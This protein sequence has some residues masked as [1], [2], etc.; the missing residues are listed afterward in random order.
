MTAGR[1]RRALVAAYFLAVSLVA[2]TLI[3][4][5]YLLDRLPLPGAVGRAYAAGFIRLFDLISR[6]FDA[7]E[8]AEERLRVPRHRGVDRERDAS[9]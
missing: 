1:V 9:D 2:A 7:L 8:P 5:G 6:P 4:V 3:A